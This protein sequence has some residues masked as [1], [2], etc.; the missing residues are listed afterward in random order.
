MRRSKHCPCASG[1]DDH[2]L[3]YIFDR[4]VRCLL[5]F[6]IPGALVVP[7]SQ[8]ILKMLLMPGVAHSDAI[9]TVVFRLDEGNEGQ[10]NGVKRGI[11]GILRR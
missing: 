4:L 6:L 1:G 7:Y 9:E 8:T 5:S 11:K 3:L 10:K 2:G